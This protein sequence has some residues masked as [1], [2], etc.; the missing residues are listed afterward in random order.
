MNHFEV[1]LCRSQLETKKPFHQNSDGVEVAGMEEFQDSIL[2]IRQLM[3][4]CYRQ[5][6]IMT[7]ID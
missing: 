2:Y 4:L 6:Q 7:G 3:K 1:Q 5:T